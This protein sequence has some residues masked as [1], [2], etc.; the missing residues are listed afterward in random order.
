MPTDQTATSFISHEVESSRLFFLDPVEDENFAVVFGG[1][2]RCAADYRIDRRD[3]PWYSLEFVSHGFGNLW[4]GGAEE[5]L[6]PGSFYVYGPSVPHRIETSPENPLGKY[7]VGFTGTEVPEFLERYDIQPGTV[8][9]CLK[10]EPIRRAFNTLIDRGIRKSRLARP[11][12]ATITR[13]LLLLCSDDAADPV[14]TDTQAYSTY[15]R[16]RDFIERNYLS[17]TSLEA[18]GNACEVD[19]P[20][21]CRLFARFCDESPYQFL[22]RLRMEHASR[23]LLESDVSVKS[24]ASALGFKDAF[25]FSRVFKSVHHVPPSRFRQS[26]HP[27]WPS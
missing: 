17:V 11:L 6:A 22:T 8:S 14:S 1:F 15:S 2:E 10:G 26:M 23:I 7:F 4:L 21:L 13:Q 25:H 24:V 18:I 19:A 5:E 3:F 9:R 16:G 20:Y 12:C 27:Q